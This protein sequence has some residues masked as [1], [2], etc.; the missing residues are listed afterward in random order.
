MRLFS[1][2]SQAFDCLPEDE[3]YRFASTFYSSVISAALCAAEF[4]ERIDE[5]AEA[6][7]QELLTLAKYF[8]EAWN[9]QEEEEA[10]EED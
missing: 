9:E 5:Q 2:P 10:E 7:R 1:V 3:E 8:S 6:Q 4:A